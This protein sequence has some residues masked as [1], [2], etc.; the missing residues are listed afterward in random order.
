M[1]RD[2][3]RGNLFQPD[4]SVMEHGSEHQVNKTGLNH[5]EEPPFQNVWKL[6]ELFDSIILFWYNV[7]DV[8]N[9]FE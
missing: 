9:Q 3:C 2:L 8:S 1:V 7:F 4:F 6:G 5:R